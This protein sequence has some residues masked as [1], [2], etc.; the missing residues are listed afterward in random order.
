MSQFYARIPL[1]DAPWA[2]SGVHLSEDVHAL[3]ANYSNEGDRIAHLLTDADARTADPFIEGAV[4][5]MRRFRMAS[6]GNQVT[7]HSDCRFAEL[8][9][10]DR[11]TS[12]FLLID[13][14]SLK[15][16]SALIEIVQWSLT[17]ELRRHK[18]KGTNVYLLAD[19]TSN[20]KI[21]D[22]TGLMTWGRGYGLRMMFFLQNFSGFI[23]TYGKQVLDTLLSEADIQQFLPGTR[24]PAVLQHAEAKLGKES[25]VV[26]RRR[27]KRGLEMDGVDYV[28]EERSVMTQDEIARCKQAILFIRKNKA[29]LVDVPRY[30]EV[31][32]WCRQ[33][34]PDPFYGDKPYL[35]PVKFRLKG[36]A[37]DIFT[38]LGRVL[39]RP[40]VKGNTNA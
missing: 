28:E 15:S 38:R 14:N 34:E 32:P 29:A 11:P 12:F 33:V 36:R 23:K 30:A 22:I 17:Q 37:R 25:V 27:R 10:P 18:N 40:S 21:H 5:G 19:E 2:T 16:Q 31:H 8:K 39:R 1:E 3:I 7:S 35:L 24:E 13:S 6:R 20:L 4:Q 9:D 26:R